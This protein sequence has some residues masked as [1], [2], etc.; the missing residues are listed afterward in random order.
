VEWSG[1]WE[2]PQG[3]SNKKSPGESARAFHSKLEENPAYDPSAGKASVVL[4]RPTY[5]ADRLDPQVP[6]DKR[7][8]EPEISRSRLHYRHF[9]LK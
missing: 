5:G 2:K 3:A 6:G 1:F 8:V 4:L 9:I 7:R